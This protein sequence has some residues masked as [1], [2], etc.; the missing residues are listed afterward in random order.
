MIIL[1]DP[2]YIHSKSFLSDEEIKYYKKKF[3]EL[4]YYYLDSIGAQTDN[5]SGIV[6]DS[7]QDVGIF[8]NGP[9]EDGFPFAHEVCEKFCNQNGIKMGEVLRTRINFTFKNED[10]RTLP[11]YIKQ[12][13]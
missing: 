12:L 4:P 5:I 6:S 8:A 11:I 3:Y 13:I 2:G 10:P 9:S 1:P 7:L